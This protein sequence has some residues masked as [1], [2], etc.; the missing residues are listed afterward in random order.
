MKRNCLR[1]HNN[2]ITDPFKTVCDECWKWRDENE[3][4]LRLNKLTDW[5]KC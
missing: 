2:K 1:C 3:I 5:S 4:K